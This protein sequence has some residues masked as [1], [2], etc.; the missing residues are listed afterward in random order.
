MFM[1]IFVIKPFHYEIGVYSKKLCSLCYEWTLFTQ[2]DYEKRI[3]KYSLTV[4]VS[5]GKYS[6]IS[7][8]TGQ[9]SR[10]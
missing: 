6:P 8:Y 3:V 7:F 9:A 2:I 5:A 10:Q 1:A 4:L